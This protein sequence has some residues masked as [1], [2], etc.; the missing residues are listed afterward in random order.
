MALPLGNLREYFT[1]PPCPSAVIQLTP[2]YVSAVLV[3]AKEGRVREHLVF[4][5]PAGLIEPRF[6]GPNIADAAALTGILKDGLKPLGFSGKRIACLVPE[7]CL[8]ILVLA[9]D[10]LPTSE[11]EREKLIRWRAKKQMPVLP[12]DVRLS[13]D[14]WPS[15]SSL[16]LLVVLART[17]VIQEY[18]GLFAG[19]GLEAGIIT[20][21]TLSLL[22]LVDWEENGDILAVNIEDDSL[23]LGAITLGVPAFYRLKM[24]GVERGNI[25]H[26][27]D[28]VET[29]VKEIENTAHFIED[30][31]KREIR[32]LWFRSGL[33]EG[34]KDIL[35]VLRTALPFDIHPI[36]VPASFGLAPDVSDFLAPLVGQIPGEK[37]RAPQLRRAE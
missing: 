12:D 34:R 15:A 18:E 27:S 13:Y 24:F 33:R 5:L 37:I 2:G 22:N 30:R 14:V 19:L 16:K 7:T 10:S 17:P 25:Q 26:F 31:E 35:E 8:K 28:K 36:Q 1:A 4:D 9:F 3:D 32:A 29:I 11:R 21:P 23:G 6:D 20:G